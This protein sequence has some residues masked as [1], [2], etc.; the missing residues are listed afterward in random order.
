MTLDAR[1]HQYQIREVSTD[2]V[3]LYATAYNRGITPDWLVAEHNRPKRVC[4]RFLPTPE[5]EAYIRDA[6]Q[7]GTSCQKLKDALF[8][9]YKIT[10]G[11]Q[12]LERY[13]RLKGYVN[14][15]LPNGCKSSIA[16]FRQRRVLKD[17]PAVEAGD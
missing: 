13:C 14:T 4:H 3:R 8:E 2:E 17:L 6:R 16:T 5:Q 7:A 10:T 12:T 9:K 15:A 11:L 1:N